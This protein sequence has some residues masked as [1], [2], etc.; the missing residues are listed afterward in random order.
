MLTTASGLRERGHRIFFCAR[1][2]GVFLERCAEAG[3]PSFPLK[4]GGDFDPLNILK[5]AAFFRKE[6]IQVIVANF[7]KDARLAGLA[8][9]LA[10][11]PVEIARNGLPILQNNWRYR[12]TYRYLVDGIVTNTMAIK[13]HYLTYGW[14]KNEFIRVIHNGIDVRQKTQY[15]PFQMAQ[16]HG[17]PN[18][19]PVVGIFGRLVKQKQHFLFLETAKKILQARPDAHFIVVGDGPLRED[20]A[21]QAENLGISASVQF[22]GLQRNV[23]EL[24]SL[25]D[26]VLLTSEDEGLPNVVMEAMLAARP[27]VAFDVGG[28]RE[29]ISESG[30]GIVTAPNDADMMAEQT[31]ALLEDQALR[32]QLGESAR[33]NIL[34]NF[35]LDKMI[36]GVEAFLSELL[37]KKGN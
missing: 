24:Y 1:K 7:N 31:V 15:D 16:K 26:V 33:Q 37:N 12:L 4:I 22:L 20:I 5:L 6:K 21:L 11:V 13:N 27:V 10:R 35:S 23:F 29:L 17:V 18:N 2:D 32:R 3:F 25:C 19:R 34:E 14:L 8:R 30:L 28:V 36:D 9:H